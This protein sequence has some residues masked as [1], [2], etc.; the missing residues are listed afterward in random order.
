MLPFPQIICDCKLAARL[1]DL[2]YYNEE[3]QTPPTPPPSEDADDEQQEQQ[4]QSTPRKC[5]RLGYMGHLIEMFETLVTNMNASE[6][7]C[8]L[9]ESTLE[10]DYAKDRWRRVIETEGGELST[11]L[12][13]Q[14]RFL[15]SDDV[16]LYELEGPLIL[17]F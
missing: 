15:V 3:M 16:S 7:F 13:L 1:V 10:G 8:A 12:A 17:C 14:K 2:W 5:R 9:V 4:Q 6:E 11:I